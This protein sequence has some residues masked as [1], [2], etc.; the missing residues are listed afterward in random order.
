[1]KSFKEFMFI[2]EKAAIPM[3]PEQIA[4]GR[5]R[6]AAAA[7]RLAQNVNTPPN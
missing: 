7:Q 4:V 1:M 6:K 5:A 3:T 2:A